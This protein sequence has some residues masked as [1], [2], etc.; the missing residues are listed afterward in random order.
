MLCRELLGVTAGWVYT[1]RVL[2]NTGNNLLCV[3]LN[4]NNFLKSQP[5]IYI[6]H[7]TQTTPNMTSPLSAGSL[8][9]NDSSHFD[10]GGSN[11][12][13]TSCPL[14]PQRALSQRSFHA[15]P[16]AGMQS[17]LNSW[18]LFPSRS[19]HTWPAACQFSLA[20][21]ELRKMLGKLFQ[22][23]ARTFCQEPSSPWQCPFRLLAI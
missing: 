21:T 17:L 2:A 9:L 6:A 20:E 11:R 1:Q 14:P 7:F 19:A 16:P 15:W 3:N 18:P 22:G 5:N 23:Q 8:S 13:D 10:Q 12:Q 4:N